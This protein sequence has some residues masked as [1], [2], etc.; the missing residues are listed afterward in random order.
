MWGNNG[1]S[2]RE[3]CI[4]RLTSGK[5]LTDISPVVLVKHSCSSNYAA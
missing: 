4:A 5:V 1:N 3:V 2:R